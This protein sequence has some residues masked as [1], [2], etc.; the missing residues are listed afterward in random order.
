MVGLEPTHYLDN[1]L[2]IKNK[3]QSTTI[4]LR[5]ILR[6]NEKNTLFINK[7]TLIY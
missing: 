6:R 1:Y 4:F 7:Q 5:L 2:T 3:T